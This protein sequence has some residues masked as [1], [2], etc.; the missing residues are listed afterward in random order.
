MLVASKQ[1]DLLKSRL[2][3]LGGVK[4]P[5]QL[6]SDKFDQRK[7][8]EWKQVPRWLRATN[9]T[10]DTHTTDTALEELKHQYPE[11]SHFETPDDLLEHIGAHERDKE[12]AAMSQAGGG[13][14]GDVGTRGRVS[15]MR[16]DINRRTRMALARE[17]ATYH[18]PHQERYRYLF[19]IAQVAQRQRT[20]TG[21]VREV[22]S[23]RILRSA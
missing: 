19:T 4:A 1:Y 23:G 5:K 13:L 2:R 8:D 16:Q 21:R 18:W 12:H 3:A 10:E 14:R 22:A 7:S 17:A 11:Y 9:P 15:K 20:S 6:A